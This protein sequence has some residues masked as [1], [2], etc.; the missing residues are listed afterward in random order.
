MRTLRTMCERESGLP[1]A[2]RF[3]IK[4]FVQLLTYKLGIL[5]FLVSF[6]FFFF[7]LFLAFVILLSLM[8]PHLF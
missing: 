5:L 6:L 7:P 1:R 8:L 2:V 3:G 4:T